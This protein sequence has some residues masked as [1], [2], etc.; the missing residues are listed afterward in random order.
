[1]SNPFGSFNQR[2]AEEPAPTTSTPAVEGAHEPPSRTSQWKSKPGDYPDSS[3]PALNLP[4]ARSISDGIARELAASDARTAAANGDQHY[5]ER[6][7]R[8]D[9]AR[10]VKVGEMSNAQAQA[11]WKAMFGDTDPSSVK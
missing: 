2:P 11:T 4:S 10:A 3:V 9:L 5:A 1:M 7:M 8:D 6:K